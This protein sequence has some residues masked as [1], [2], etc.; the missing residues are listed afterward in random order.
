MDSSELKVGDKIYIMKAEHPPRQYSSQILDILNEKEYVIAGP[1][2]RSTI[3]HVELNS[4]IVV[5]YYKER[6]GKFVFRAL[7]KEV[8]EKGI[9]KLKVERLNEIVKIQDRNYFRLPISLEVE[10]EYNAE[11]VYDIENGNDIETEKEICITG[12]ISGGGLK[13]FSNIK[14]RERDKIRINF[15]IKD[16]EVSTIGEVIRVSKAKNNAYKYKYEI[17]VKFLDIDNYERDAIVKYIFEQEREL[18]KKRI[19]FNDY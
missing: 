2:R 13:L 4:V 14:H 9:Y 1:I 11:Q 6:I 17:G 12:D 16:V 5:N 8:W 19:D 15:I 10:K 7:V 3:I 18:R